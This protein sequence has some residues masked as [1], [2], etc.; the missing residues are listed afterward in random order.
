MY[1]WLWFTARAYVEGRAPSPDTRAG[2]PKS[3]STGIT[4]NISVSPQGRREHCK[5]SQSEEQNP[6]ILVMWHCNLPHQRSSLYKE[7]A[8]WK[9]WLKPCPTPCLTFQYSVIFNLAYTTFFSYTTF[10]CRHFKYSL[11]IFFMKTF[12]LTVHHK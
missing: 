9:W 12:T 5:H 3:K 11:A 8:T 4:I 7:F 2:T 10:R 1:G 6:L